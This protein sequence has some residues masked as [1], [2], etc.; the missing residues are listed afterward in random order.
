MYQIFVK[1]RCTNRGKTYK[2]DVSN[3]TTMIEFKKKV[4]QRTQIPS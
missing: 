1:D 2:I 4:F 3:N